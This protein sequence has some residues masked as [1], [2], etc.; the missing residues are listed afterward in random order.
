VRTPKLKTQTVVANRP[1]S[2]VPPHTLTN[3]VLPCH[4][5]A[6]LLCVPSAR[7]GA[8]R[9]A[10][11]RGARRREGVGVLVD[12]PRQ[13]RPLQR[14]VRPCAHTRPGMGMFS[15]F[16]GNRPAKRDVHSAPPAL[17]GNSRRS[18]T[19]AS[20]VPDGECLSDSQLRRP[21]RGVA[22]RTAL[23]QLARVLWTRAHAQAGVLLRRPARLRPRSC[24]WLRPP[25][26]TFRRRSRAASSAWPR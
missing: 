13:D 5:S 3:G 9:A 20:S 4:N 12:S 2:S 6:A 17:D 11:R 16:N 24:S 25:R 18:A 14:L 19:T 7:E 1:R 15:C 21:L 8:G 10:V 23:R 26:T 22:L